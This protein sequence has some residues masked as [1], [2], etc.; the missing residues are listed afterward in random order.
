MNELDKKTLDIIFQKVDLLDLMYNLCGYIQE[1]NK[2]IVEIK[3]A[4][5]EQT[6]LEINPL[7]TEQRRKLRNGG[8]MLKSIMRTIKQGQHIK[9]NHGRANNG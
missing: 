2:E 3:K 7:T 8:D 1:T 4:Y 9:E 6:G 5:A